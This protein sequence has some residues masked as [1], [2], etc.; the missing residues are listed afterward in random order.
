MAN[1]Q[2]MTQA[3]MQ[4]A[5]KAVKA[6]VQALA[7]TRAEA[8]T[9][10]SSEAVSTGSRLGTPSLQ[11]LL[12]D[13]NARDQYVELRNL[14]L[15]VNNI[16]CIKH[17]AWIMQTEYQLLRTGY[18][19]KVYIS[20]NLS[21]RQSKEACRTVEGLFKTLHRKSGLSIMRQLYHN[22]TVN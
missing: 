2:A 12:F 3:I 7:V 20:Y 14:R 19:G 16:N 22:N 15:E 11:Q 17:T 5:I 1:T 21:H 18:V 10:L 13:W 4:A 8:G 6:V 9:G